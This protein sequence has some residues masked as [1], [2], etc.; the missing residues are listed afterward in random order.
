MSLTMKSICGSSVSL[1][2]RIRSSIPSQ[3]LS[4]IGTEHSL[5]ADF[6]CELARDHSARKIALACLQGVVPPKKS[7]L[8]ACKPHFWYRNMAC[9]C[10]RAPPSEKT[11]LASTQGFGEQWKRFLQGCKEITLVLFAS[12]EWIV[13]I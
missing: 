2:L 11:P 1:I 3:K 12:Y 5:G 13:D 4:L 6:P 10:A 9:A 8:H 7:A